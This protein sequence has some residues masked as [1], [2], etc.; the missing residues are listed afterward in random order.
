MW[1]SYCGVNASLSKILSDFDAAASHSELTVNS[2]LCPSP[3]VPS[4]PASAPPLYSFARSFLSVCPTSWRRS[5][6]CRT[7]CWGHPPSSWC[8]AG[9]SVYSATALA[10]ASG[11]PNKHRNAR[12]SNT[13]EKRPIFC[14]VFYKVVIFYWVTALLIQELW[15]ADRHDS[16][17]LISDYITEKGKKGGGKKGG[18]RAGELCPSSSDVPSFSF[19]L[20]LPTCFRL[21]REQGVTAAEGKQSAPVSTHNKWGADSVWFVLWSR[22]AQ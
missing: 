10:L 19:L 22:P 5:I 15:I 3:Q 21:R 7:V 12:K 2:E 14:F 20:L 9:E 13:K 16:S 6:C 8:R 18:G 11:H 1:C 17:A 4:T